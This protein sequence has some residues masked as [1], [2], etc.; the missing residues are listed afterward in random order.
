MGKTTYKPPNQDGGGAALTIQE[1]DR[2][3][4]LLAA[5]GYTWHLKTWVQR[6]RSYSRSWVLVAPD[7]K[8]IDVAVALALIAMSLCAASEQPAVRGRDG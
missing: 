1:R 7:G 6:G 8:E 4:A 3:N 2:Q 5:Y